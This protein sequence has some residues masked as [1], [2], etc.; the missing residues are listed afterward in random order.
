MLK[1]AF[2]SSIVQMV[3][4]FLT[5]FELSSMKV[6]NGKWF[7]IFPLILFLHYSFS[8][9]IWL[10][11]SEELLNSSEVNLT[12]LILLKKVALTFGS[13]FFLHRFYISELNLS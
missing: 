4:A 1:D 11:N 2:L 7:L 3:F 6:I 13:T 10:G 9:R 8:A 12:P 5:V